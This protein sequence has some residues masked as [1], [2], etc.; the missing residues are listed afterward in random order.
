LEQFEAEDKEVWKLHFPEYY[1]ERLG[2]EFF[3]EVYSSGKTGEA[4]GREFLRARGLLECHTAREIVAGLSAFDTMMLVD[5]EPGLLNKISTEKL[6]RKI[7]ALMKAFGQ[8]EC[9]KDWL[10][11][12]GKEAGSWK[13][14]VNWD[15]AS[16][17]DPNLKPEDSALRIQSVEE[18]VKRGMVQDADLLKAQAKLKERGG[19]TW[20]PGKF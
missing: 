13:S 16:R 18:E 1:R 11:P 19:D 9:E 3:A 12:S 14:K 2:P 6:A 17:I 10:K 5:K 7:Y 15:A 4:Y 8:V 20:K